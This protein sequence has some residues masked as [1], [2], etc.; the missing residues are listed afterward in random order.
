MFAILGHP[1]LY[2]LLSVY[3]QNNQSKILS[4][5]FGYEKQKMDCSSHLN[6]LQEG[7]LMRWEGNRN[8]IEANSGKHWSKMLRLLWDCDW[9]RKKAESL[10]PGHVSV[11]L[12][13]KGLYG[14]AS[15]WKRWKKDRIY[16]MCSGKAD[17]EPTISAGKR[18]KKKWRSNSWMLESSDHGGGECR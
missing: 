16:C 18:G 4:N 9:C 1:T 13:W 12:G 11:I 10:H 15:G 5:T 3:R 7:G 6:V 8:E 14:S 17:P 2:N